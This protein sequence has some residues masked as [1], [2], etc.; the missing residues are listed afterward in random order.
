MKTV[1]KHTQTTHVQQRH[2]FTQKRKARILC[3]HNKTHKK[4]GNAY[5]LMKLFG[6][7]RKHRLPKSD[8]IHCICAAQVLRKKKFFIIVTCDAE[9][10]KYTMHA[11]LMPT[12]MLLGVIQLIPSL[13]KRLVYKICKKT[14]GGGDTKSIVQ[15]TAAATAAPAVVIGTAVA[16]DKG[17]KGD[18]T[19]TKP[20]DADTTPELTNADTTPETIID[21][22][23]LIKR[24]YH[25][26]LDTSQTGNYQYSFSLKDGKTIIHRDTAS[27]SNDIIKQSP[28]SEPQTGFSASQTKITSMKEQIQPSTPSEIDLVNRLDSENNDIYEA[29]FD[30]GHTIYYTL[31]TDKE[32][33]TQF[34]IIASKPKYS[35]E[36]EDPDKE[37]LGSDI[38]YSELREGGI[39]VEAYSDLDPSPSATTLLQAG[40]TPEQ[41]YFARKHYNQ[42]SENGS[43]FSPEDLKEAGVGL[44]EMHDIGIPAHELT[45]DSW[46]VSGPDGKPISVQINDNNEVINKDGTSSSNPQLTWK[47]NET[48]GTPEYEYTY[49]S[50]VANEDKYT[51]DSTNKTIEFNGKQYNPDEGSHTTF[52]IDGKTI[53]VGASNNNELT[54]TEVLGDKHQDTPLFEA[55]EV[56]S[57]YG[58]DNVENINEAVQR[59]SKLYTED[60][61]RSAGIE[62][63]VQDAG[64]QDAGVQDAGAQDTENNQLLMTK[65]LAAIGLSSVFSQVLVVFFAICGVIF[66]LHNEN[67][68]TDSSRYFTF[69]R[70]IL[71]R[72]KTQQKIDDFHRKFEKKIYQTNFVFEKTLEFQPTR[73][74]LEKYLRKCA[75]DQMVQ[76]LGY[77][78]R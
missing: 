45:K 28:E 66:L 47:V 49:T 37:T 54:I 68:K 30:D 6:E 60:E 46:T 67:K 31:G 3:A 39:P 58:K 20:T 48:T 77:S 63:N 50:N 21:E 14:S 40:Y 17:E 69:Y 76:I 13:F 7:H 73:D 62:P 27:K 24:Y 56:V 61:L 4:G 15:A 52:T 26:E 71:K 1:K 65:I 64:A 22:S 33:N 57:V 53:E 36:T 16:L 51:Y 74:S 8:K 10:K 23:Y 12:S 18:K 43:W 5:V 19:T 9:E 41:L 38:S 42:N 78:Q 75:R 34:T 25:K 35:L 29:K 70:K 72:L 32:N 59:D 55:N 44:Q 2:P 11:R